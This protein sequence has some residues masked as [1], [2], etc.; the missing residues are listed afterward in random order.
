MNIRN[1][2][3]IAHIDH[4]KS[5]LADRLLELTSTI[6]QRK[7]REQFLDTMDIERERGITIKMQPVRMYYNYGGQTYELNLIDTPG[8]V[9]FT[10][11]VSRALAAV[12]GAV[13]LIDATQGIQAQT[14][15]NLHLAK[16]ENLK[17]IGI[18]NKIDLVGDLEKLESLKIEIAKLTGQ[19]PEEILMVSAKTGVNI[20]S[21]LEKVIKEFP[22]PK[23]NISGQ[24]R[25][26]IF[27]SHFDAYKGVIAYIKVFDGEISKQK[28]IIALAT[29]AKF[30]VIETGIFKPELAQKDSL[31]SGEIGYVAT[32]LKNPSLIKVGD[33]LAGAAGTKPFPGYSEPKPFVWASF[34][35]ESADDFDLLKTALPKLKLNDAALHFE[36]ETQEALGRGFRLGFLGM[37]HLDITVERLKREHNLNIVVTTPTVSY[38][39]I[40]KKGN[41]GEIF[42][43]ADWPDP[44][45][46]ETVEEPW[47]HLE[48]LMPTRYLGSVMKLVGNYRGIYI[49]TDYLGVDHLI[50]NYDIPISDI[51]VDFHDRLKSASEG[52]ASMNYRL[53][54]FRPYDLVKL[55]I[56]IAGEPVEAFSKI[57]P[58]ALAH[59]E[60]GAIVKKLKDIVPRQNFAVALQAAIGGKVIAR[61]TIPAMR[62]DV[63]GYLYGGDVTRKMKLL[64]KQKKSKKKRA[65]FG[66]VELDSDVYLKMFRSAE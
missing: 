17:I 53:I 37:L 49:N 34:Y 16:K 48:I 50:I 10:Y 45:Q 52:Y 18:I 9:D 31:A 21:I 14:L 38:R 13:L 43:P 42:T 8:H 44:S 51:L 56:L 58:R 65:A 28:N 1:F 47:V 57:M 4:G 25:A 41:I 46:V 54:G 40:Y 20:E 32:G 33:T 24:F 7:M 36:P 22:A 61:E 3:I 64:E 35:P 2:V 62:K 19:K 63:T 15:A 66:R 55:Q 11:E 12:E 30:Q 26:L 6:A 59:R 29:G 23:I 39:I 5:T 27:D 60:G